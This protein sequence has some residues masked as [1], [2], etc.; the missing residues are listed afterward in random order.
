M[1][2]NVSTV[3]TTSRTE[4]SCAARVSRKPPA[5]PGLDS[6]RPAREVFT[7]V[8]PGFRVADLV[9]ILS[10]LDIVVPDIDR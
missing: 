8:A 9:A 10:T 4:I 2:S 1:R 6:T 3:F 5:R 7:K